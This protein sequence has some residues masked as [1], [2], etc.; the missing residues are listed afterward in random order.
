MEVDI[1]NQKGEKQSKGK[2]PQGVFALEP[3]DA[4]VHQVVVC[5]ASNQRQGTAHTKDRSEVSGGGRKPWRQKGTGRARHGSR[6]SPIW[7]GGGVT[8]G[9]RNERNYKKRIPLKMRR[10]ALCMALSSRAKEGNLFLINEFN[11]AKISTKEMAGLLKALPLKG[12]SVLVVQSDN[13]KNLVLS[14]RNIPKA[15]ILIAKDLTALDV[16]Q[17]KYLVIEQ[18]ALAVLE[19]Q[20]V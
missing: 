19:K 4:L 6:R 3:N 14:T 18:P 13:K 20:L 5:Q 17:R 9:P 1:Y 8:F 16:L 11:S 10:Q 15:S 2:L 7:A 12:G